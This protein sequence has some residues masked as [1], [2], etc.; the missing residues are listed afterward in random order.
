MGN[1]W[2]PKNQG[3]YLLEAVW[4]ELRAQQAM[5]RHRE[6]SFWGPLSGYLFFST[7]HV[8]S[9][10]LSILPL[11]SA[12]SDYIPYFAGEGTKAL[13]KNLFKLQS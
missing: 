4:T 3:F 11:L 12:L 8:T 2:D 1:S 9:S 7:Y 13:F 5:L 6:I 10:M